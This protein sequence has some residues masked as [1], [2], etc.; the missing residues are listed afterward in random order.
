MVGI[1]TLAIVAAAGVSWRAEMRNREELTAELASTKQALQAADARQSERDAK[2]ADTLAAI[3]AQKRA[4]QSPAQI[5]K[6]LPLQLPLPLPITLQ[7]V[8][9][10]SMPA[11]KARNQSASSPAVPGDAA[12]GAGD[13]AKIQGVIPGQDLKPLYDFALDCQACQAKLAASQSDLADEQGKTKALTKERDDALR[14]A[15]GGSI[16]KRVGRA[17]KWML[18]GAAA[19]AVAARTV[20]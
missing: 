17:A 1:V 8:P 6:A 19:G 15:R 4:V 14:V 16:W 5:L 9:G 12:P 7:E 13:L 20:H 18:I 2:L 11:S 10:S 3:A